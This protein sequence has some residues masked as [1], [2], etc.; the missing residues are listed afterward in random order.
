MVERGWGWNEDVEWSEVSMDANK[1]WRK[2]GIYAARENNLKEKMRA[3][4]NSIFAYVGVKSLLSEETETDDD[5][6]LSEQSDTDAS[7]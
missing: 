3:L 5:L 6:S 1:T 7:E 4:Q 2:H